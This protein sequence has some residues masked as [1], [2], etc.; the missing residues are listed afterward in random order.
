MNTTSQRAEALLQGPRGRRLLLQY[1]TASERLHDPEYRENGFS[2]GASLASYLLDPDRVGSVQLFGD[3][4]AETPF[5]TPEEVA[6]RLAS[7]PLAEVTPALLRD[8]FAEAVGWARYWQEPDGEDVLCATDELRASLRRVAE[9]VA[10]SPHTAWWSE[11]VAE[12]SQW[13]VE[14]EDA[15]HHEI[16]AD[17]MASLHKERDTIIEEE[18]MAIQER[19]SDPTANWSGTWW[20]RPTRELPHTSRALFDGSAAGLWLVEDKMGREQAD[21]RQLGVSAGLRIY[22]IDTAEAWA[23]FCARFPI[24]VTAQ[25]RHDW[26]RTT[27]R[28]GA[29]VIP[30]WAKVAKH[31][32]AVHLQAQTYLSAAGT[33][34][35]V[36]EQTASVIGGWDPDETF[37][38]TPNVRFIDSPIKWVFQDGGEQ[39]DWV[40]QE[41][42]P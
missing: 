31:Y 40:R 5:I 12:R 39:N 2:A 38:F 33:V 28:D 6:K 24:E 35:P 10:A 9:H 36:D 15:P 25:K 16:L 29:W 22:E 7:V 19:P 3:G 26:Y 14:W 11:P 1:A 4:A 18:L 30:D 17:P 42:S 32:D 23:D 37:W 21:T 8:C 20:S 41:D 27:G 34:I 13:Q